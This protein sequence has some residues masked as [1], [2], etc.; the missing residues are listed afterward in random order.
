MCA[1]CGPFAFFKWIVT[2]RPLGVS[3][4]VAAPLSPEPFFGFRGTVS[5]LEIPAILDME[6]PVAATVGAFTASSDAVANAAA[7]RA[8]L[9]ESYLRTNDLNGVTVRGRRIVPAGSPQCRLRSAE[10]GCLQPA[11]GRLM[12]YNQ[13]TA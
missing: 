3:R 10:S 1:G 11:D 2:T 12:M 6:S 9:I 8:I 4:S 7:T 13:R 5:P